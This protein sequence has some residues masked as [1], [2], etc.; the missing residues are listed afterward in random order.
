MKKNTKNEY[1]IVLTP[2][3]NNFFVSINSKTGHLY[4]VFSFAHVKVLAGE[5]RR[6]KIFAQEFGAFFGK[7]LTS[8]NIVGDFTV[9]LKGVD[10]RSFG[11]LEH[12]IKNG[13]GFTQ[14][15]VKALG[16]FN[17]CRTAKQKRL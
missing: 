16:A 4:R 13:G 17:G 9:K 8:L 5:H 12:Y 7:Y 14:I 6:R 1:L 10:P 11:F 15:I 3:I 2:T